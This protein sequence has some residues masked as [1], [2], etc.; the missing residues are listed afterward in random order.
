MTARFCFNAVTL[1]VHPCA[2]KLVKHLFELSLAFVRLLQRLSQ[3]CA[4]KE[5]LANG[6]RHGGATAFY[7]ELKQV[8]GEIQL[9]ISDN[10]SGVSGEI[11]EGFGLKGMREKAEALGGKCVYTSEQGEGFENRIADK[12]EAVGVGLHLAH[13]I[14]RLNVGAVYRLRNNVYGGGLYSR[15][16]FN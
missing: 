6:I 13:V 11:E 12:A 15:S 7:I 16:V 10:G 1:L 9:I 14:T 3:L 5:L 2:G 4:V 8:F